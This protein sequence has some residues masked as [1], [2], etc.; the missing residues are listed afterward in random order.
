M[1]A[2][3]P[4]VTTTTFPPIGAMPNE[5]LMRMLQIALSNYGMPSGI[6]YGPR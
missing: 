2:M 4:P 5:E 6:G 3:P 1:S